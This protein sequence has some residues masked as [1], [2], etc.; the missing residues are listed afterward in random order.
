MTESK[1]RLKLS[2]EEEKIKKSWGTNLVCVSESDLA[3]FSLSTQTH[4]FL[5]RVGLPRNCPLLVSFYEDNRLLH[6]VKSEDENYLMLGE[7]NG[8]IFCLKEK[9]EEVWSIDP[10]G[11]LPSRFINSSIR[12]FFTFLYI[13]LS[14]QEALKNASD[15]EAGNIVRQLRTEF[16]GIDDRALLESE[17]WWSVIL[18]EIEYGLY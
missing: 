10:E 8:T 16:E 9:C 12:S 17:N 18:E 7:D 11:E 3:K 2:K 4:N 14:H 5:V 6:P 1:N 15:E 13:Y